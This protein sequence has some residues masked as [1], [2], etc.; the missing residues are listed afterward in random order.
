VLFAENGHQDVGTGHLTLARG[1]HVKNSALQDALEAQRGLGFPI[2]IIGRDQWRGCIHKLQEF[3]TQSTQVSATCFQNWAAATRTTT[4]APS[5][6]IRAAVR[7]TSA[8]TT[9]TARAA[10]AR[11]RRTSPR[12]PGGTAAISS[13]PCPRIPGGALPRR[14]RTCRS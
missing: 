7:P 4:A 10:P 5:P 11:A 8:A 1:L 12:T 2:Q 13:C 3:A 14:L 6:R 9:R